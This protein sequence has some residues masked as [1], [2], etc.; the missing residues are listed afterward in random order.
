LGFLLLTFSACAVLLGIPKPQRTRDP[1]LTWLLKFSLVVNRFRIWYSFVLLGYLWFR[2]VDHLRIEWSLNEQYAYG[3]AV[4]FLC[5]FL[6]HRRLSSKVESA[7]PSSGRPIDQ[8][9]RNGFLARPTVLA[10]LGV[11]LLVAFLVTRW[12]EIANPDWRLVSWG[13]ALEVV[14]LTL[15]F[16]EALGG[17]ELRRRFTFPLLFFLIAI[18]WP[19]I[20]EHSVVQ[21]LTRT[22]VALTVETLQLAGRV[23]IAHGNVIE[24]AGGFVDVDEACSGIRSLQ[25]ALMLALFFGEWHGL[26]WRRRFYLLVAALGLAVLFNFAR[27]A[28]LSFIAAGQGSSAIQRWHDP[29][30]III[31]IGCFCGIWWIAGRLAR[32]ARGAATHLQSVSKTSESAADVA[33]LEAAGSG[34]MKKP[35]LYFT[36]V[37]VALLF[38]G[39]V[40]IHVWYLP[41]TQVQA[42]DW[43]IPAPTNVAFQRIELPEATRK[44][45]RYNNGIS[46]AWRDGNGNIWQLFFF[47]WNPGRVA[48]TLAR[49]HTPEICLPAAGKKL[50]NISAPIEISA[51]ALRLPFRCY[52]AAGRDQPLFVFYSLTEDGAGTQSVYSDSLTWSR[53]IEAVLQRRKN[54]GQRVIEIALTGPATRADAEQLLRSNLPLLIRVD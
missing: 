54:P 46:G 48:V 53:R 39:E 35:T 36:M 12:I 33:R 50:Q 18:P 31:L 25:A 47:R 28:V 43:S 26:N 44:I 38:A 34:V 32:H 23:A 6:A 37:T 20:V 22:I 19:T 52:T 1:L 5:A 4:P 27:T 17:P 2:L 15:L 16:I 29:A 49:N 21:T 11:T 10:S 7:V 40:F 45:L 42:I 13:M 24:T 14:A 51:G 3:F 8:T 41:S 9:P 30:G